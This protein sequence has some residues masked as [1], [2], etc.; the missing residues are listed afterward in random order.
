MTEPG[1]SGVRSPAHAGRRIGVAVAVA[2]ATVAI[3]VS[4]VV[5]VTAVQVDRGEIAY[6]QSCA[7]CH[8]PNGDDGFAPAIS[9]PQSL[10][11]Y[12]TVRAVYDFVRVTMPL[13]APGSLGDQTYLDVVAYLLSTRGSTPDGEELSAA[14]LDT[15]PLDP[16]AGRALRVVA[17]EYI[18]P[19]PNLAHNL[20]DLELQI[21]GQS[22]ACSFRQ[23]YYATGGLTR[24]GFPTSE[25]L[26]ER[27]NAFTQYYQRGAV[28]CHQR[29]GGW[30]VERRLAWDYIGGGLGQSV[31][32]GVEPDLLNPN[33]GTVAGPWGHKV[34]N[35]DVNDTQTGFL[36]FYEAL[37][38]VSAF[39][40]PKSEARRDDD[41]RAVLNIPGA[42]RG[43]VRQYFQST[44]MEFHP[45]DPDPVKLRLLGDDLRDR[46]Y[47]SRQWEKFVSF[48]PAAA[49]AV[50]ANY[51]PE[52]T[53]PGA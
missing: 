23:H 14:T 40:F 9:G 5:A 24:W 35:V 7:V 2:I 30:L 53:A 21:D 1:V 43:F 27:A 33:P 47:P 48:G 37:G 10:R 41:P 51:V 38:G 12:G 22:V 31:D 26:E 42:T 13:S 20:V 16:P 52:R 15:T 11:Q 34:S 32:L 25:V 45:G 17:T 3:T 28:D 50:G 8:G 4:A 6:A 29:G 44:V 39:G 36:D 46:I 19:D 49:A 18:V